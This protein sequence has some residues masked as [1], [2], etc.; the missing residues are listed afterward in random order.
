[1]GQATAIAIYTS[2]VHQL[3]KTGDTL[4]DES[5]NPIVFGTVSSVAGRTGDVVITT[6]DLADFDTA[7]SANADVVANTA[8]KHTHANKAILDVIDQDL[9][10]TDS[11]LFAGLKLAGSGGSETVQLLGPASG[12]AYSIRL[13]SGSPGGTKIM[14]IDAGGTISWIDT[15]TSA[16]YMTVALSAE[17]SKIITHNFGKYPDVDFLPAGGGARERPGSVTDADANQL[18]VTFST[19]VTGTVVLRA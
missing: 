13:P 12:T 11:P 2:G 10:T 14:Q 3:L 19:P 9:A 6:S 7:V 17:S 16:Q 1:M 8:A 4:V 5:G 15:P 18:T